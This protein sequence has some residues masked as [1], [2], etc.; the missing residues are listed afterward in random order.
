MRKRYKYAIVL[1]II[2]AAQCVLC[3]YCLWGGLL[4]FG[5]ETLAILLAI[6]IYLI[7]GALKHTNWYRNVLVYT[8]Q[9]CSNKGYRDYLIR[10]I[11]VA[12]VGSNPARFAF[13]YDTILGENWSTG[14]QGLD[15]DFEILKF[16]HSFIK[17]GGYV[18]L[19]IMPFSSISGY[20]RLYKS[21]EMG[22]EYYA[23]FA[24]TLDRRQASKIPECRTAFKWLKYPFL[25]KP[26]AIKYLFFDQQPDNRLQISEQPM[27]MPQ[28]IEDSRHRIDGWL[29][30]FKLKSLND[31]FSPELMEGFS[32]SVKKMQEIVDFLEE[33]ELKP[34][35]ILTPMSAPL[36]QYF[37]PDINKRFVYDFIEAIDRPSARFL[38]YSNAEQ[39]QNPSL[40]FNSLFMNLRG[41]KL[42]TR[43]VLED[44]GL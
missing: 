17:R 33:R 28:L 18:L 29:K 1:A 30:E 15:W 34:V 38:D 31:S 37:T 26:K 32:V 21:N 40:Y 44:L 7:N 13:H 42:F 9:M 19:P 3:Y 36:Q 43:K 11:E 2:M 24:H 20:L 6:V 27:M 10:N 4:V 14:N 23:K 41:R 16:R 35:L 8:N 12:N 22:M 39:F 25:V 5:L